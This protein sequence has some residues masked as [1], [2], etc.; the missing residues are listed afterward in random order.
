MRFQ[1]AA[2]P[3]PGG[4]KIQDDDFSFLLR[5]RIGRAV[6]RFTQGEIVGLFGVGVSF[7]FRSVERGNGVVVGLQEVIAEPLI[8]TMREPPDVPEFLAYL[9]AIGCASRSVSK[10]KGSGIFL[11]GP[12]QI[13]F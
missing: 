8:G 2:R 4:P 13:F 3:A 10:R 12:G 6:L 9:V 7:W 1:L 11:D 5:E